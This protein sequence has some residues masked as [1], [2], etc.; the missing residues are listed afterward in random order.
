[1][2][3]LLRG[4]MVFDGTGFKHSDILISDGIVS[5]IAPS[6][7]S[8]GDGLSCSGVSADKII[9]LNNKYIFPGFV[10]V[11]VHFREPGFTYKEDIATGSASAAAGGYTDVCAMPNLNPVPDSPERLEVEL[12]AIKEKAQIHVY[13]YGSLSVD[14]K[15]EKL[16]AIE[17]MAADVIAFSDDGRGLAGDALML[18]AMERVKK[19]GRLIAAHCEDMTVIGGAHVHD[20]EIAKR[21][22]INGITSESEWKMVERDV[23]LAKET[24]WP[25]HVC[26]VSTKESVEI[27][28]KAKA[29]GV[30]ITCETGPHYLLLD[31]NDILKA[32]EAEA[33]EELG[34]FKMNP[35]LRSSEDRKALIEGLL[36]GTIEMIATDHAPHAS[37]EKAKGLLGAPMGVVGLECAFPV[38]HAGLVRTGIMTLERLVTLMSIVPAKRVGIESGIREGAEAK[39]CVYDLNDE[40][41]ISPDTFMSKGRYTPFDGSKVYARC[42]MTVCGKE[43]VWNAPG[44]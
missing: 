27:I 8:A 16:S 18:E 32:M 11:H 5:S 38:L 9:D 14:E 29:E 35:P 36:D 39:L 20:G 2:L 23:K 37:E 1:M 25:Y 13:P 26:H 40:Y 7:L 10:D 24:G 15:G 22:G 43:T 30:N 34:R 12:E 21:L 44:A 17:A 33:P 4:G 3:T 42:L 6:A 41:C 19:S 31:E 28:R